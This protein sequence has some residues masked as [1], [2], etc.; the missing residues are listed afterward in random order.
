M[1][2]IWDSHLFPPTLLY[3][4]VLGSRVKQV[5]HY[6]SS[7]R[8]VLFSLGCDKKLNGI[9]LFPPQLLAFHMNQGISFSSGPYFSPDTACI[10][11]E[12]IRKNVMDNGYP[13]GP[14]QENASGTEKPT[15]MMSFIPMAFSDNFS[16]FVTI[17]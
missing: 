8:I 6:L 12:D 15:M 9:E 11:Q 16:A 4:L 2:L 10:S 1:I 14:S 13:W 5:D 17:L 7:Q 3:L